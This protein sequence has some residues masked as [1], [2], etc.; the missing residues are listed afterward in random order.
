MQSVCKVMMQSLGK[1]WIYGTCNLRLS[2]RANAETTRQ[3]G[4]PTPT[5]ASSQPP[6]RT[7]IGG[8]AHAQHGERT[9]APRH[10]KPPRQ[11]G[12]ARSG[13]GDRLCLGR[14]AQPSPCSS[15]PHRS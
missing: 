10:G 6:Q 13:V 1:Q 5:L 9:E 4:N 3:Q 11:R 14:Q 7:S 2:E 12:P 8:G 15:E